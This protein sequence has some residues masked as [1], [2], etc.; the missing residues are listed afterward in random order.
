MGLFDLFNTS[1][2]TSSGGGF[3]LN[4]LLGTQVP[5]FLKANLTE[6]ELNKLQSQSNLRTGIGAIGGYASQLYQNKS[7]LQ[8]LLGIY[9]GAAEG[10]QAPY[11]QTQQ[12]LMTG[13][14][15]TK[16]IQ[17]VT[18]GKYENQFLKDKYEAAQDAINKT[19]DPALKR[20]YKLDP[21]GTL[22]IVMESMTPKAP[23]R[24]EPVYDFIRAFQLDPN[25]P[26]DA[27]KILKFQLG[28]MDQKDVIDAEVKKATLGAEFPQAA[29]KIR[30]PKSKMDVV[31][32]LINST[33]KNAPQQN[34]ST[35]TA[36]VNINVPSTEMFPT[37]AEQNIYQQG[38]TPVV[39]KPTPVSSTTQRVPNAPQVQG[40]TD[41]T[42]GNKAFVPEN[43]PISEKN[44]NKLIENRNSDTAKLRNNINNNNSLR[45]DI[46]A[47]QNHNGAKILFSAGG[48]LKAPLSREGASAQ[49]LLNKI[50]SSGTVNELI[51]MKETGPNGATPFG[52][53]NGGELQI[54]KDKFSVIKGGANYQ[55]SMNALKVIVDLLDKAEGSSRD[56]YK[57]NYGNYGDKYI[58]NKL[59]TVV[60]IPTGSD[61]PPIPAYLGSTIQGRYLNNPNIKQDRYY[62]INPDGT[63][64]EVLKADGKPY[65]KT[66]NL[67]RKR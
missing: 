51:N 19:N 44:Q 43:A 41:V 55:E 14:Q 1:S 10:R 52:Q 63:Y 21:E 8:K 12:N 58:P 48:S 28:G 37:S 11:T 35:Q 34:I 61:A 24:S 22:K 47:L 50:T 60:S 66:D 65:T 20:A 16:L 36:P 33:I 25:N 26:V 7:P 64:Q 6:D 3:S 57:M 56:L 31:N 4:S 23:T 45:E 32:E 2:D 15:G 67:N 17:D 49:R 39:Q 13:L 9:T 59:E 27:A 42:G 54:M 5:E 29:S 18:K 40:T 30:E 62:S 38:A 46:Q 53:L